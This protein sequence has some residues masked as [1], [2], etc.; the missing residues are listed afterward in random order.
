MRPMIKPAT[1]ERALDRESS[2]R[3][4]SLQTVTLTTEQ[5]QQGLSLAFDGF[6]EL[7]FPPVGLFHQSPETRLEV[8]VLGLQAAC[9]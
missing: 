6:T 9:S 5:H 7:R 4:F 2:C 8:N 1:E 3:V